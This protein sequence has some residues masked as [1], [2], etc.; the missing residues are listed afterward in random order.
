MRG[1]GLHLRHHPCQ[2]DGSRVDIT[3]QNASLERFNVDTTGLTFV[4]TSSQLTEPRQRF[5][6]LI[7]FLPLHVTSE[8]SREA[9]Q[10][11]FRID[12]QKKEETGCLRRPVSVSARPQLED[13]LRC[14]LELPVIDSTPKVTLPNPING[15]Y[16]PRNSWV[17]VRL[18]WRRRTG[19]IRVRSPFGKAGRPV[20]GMAKDSEQSFHGVN[21]GG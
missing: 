21:G 18:G 15:L 4:D 20:R 3:L 11:D 1:L 7:K 16:L 12:D 14:E 17:P 19:R 6:A 8:V 5:A 13:K 9:T 10:L 2:P